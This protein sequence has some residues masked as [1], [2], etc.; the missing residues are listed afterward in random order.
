MSR[1]KGAVGSHLVLPA[2]PP[3]HPSEAPGL[4]SL[5]K[6]GSPGG[7][8]CSKVGDPDPTQIVVSG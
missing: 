5:E 2:T 7:G 8:Q 6:Q 3:P 4:L 1:L